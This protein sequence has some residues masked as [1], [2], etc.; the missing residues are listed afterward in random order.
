MVRT[1]HTNVI[2]WRESWATIASMQQLQYLIV[3]INCDQFH[4][5]HIDELCSTHEQLI[6][7]EPSKVTRPKVWLLYLTWPKLERTID[8]DVDVREP[9]EIRRHHRHSL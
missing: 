8:N 7:V 9:F 2:D 1:T 4:W 6:L 5:L 3:L